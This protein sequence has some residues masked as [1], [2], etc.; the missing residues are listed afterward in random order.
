MDN[1]G[2]IDQ[3]QK[4]DKLRK[5]E[6]LGKTHFPIYKLEAPKKPI[7]DSVVREVERATL[8]TFQVLD[9]DTTKYQRG[10]RFEDLINVWAK[11]E[12]NQRTFPRKKNIDES[13]LVIVLSTLPVLDYKGVNIMH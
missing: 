3:A 1:E 10:I 7:S 4:P 12:Q 6:V 2:I 13:M 8:T 5:K 11:N 9:E